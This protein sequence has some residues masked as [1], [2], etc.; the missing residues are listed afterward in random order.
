MSVL[1]SDATLEG[2]L[3]WGY[4]ILIDGISLT[5]LNEKRSMGASG[6]YEEDEE[7]FE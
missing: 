6:N 1:I 5:E 2:R 3:G 7:L 4:D